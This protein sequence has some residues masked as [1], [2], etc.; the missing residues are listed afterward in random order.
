[1]LSGWSFSTRGKSFDS[2][3]SPRPSVLCR[4]RF[5]A[6]MPANAVFQIST[7]SD[8]F[9]SCFLAEQNVAVKHA[10][11]GNIGARGFEPPTSWSQTTRSTKLSYAPLNRRDLYH[12][13]SPAACR[14]FSERHCRGCALLRH[15]SITIKLASRET[16][17]ADLGSLRQC[18][19]SGRPGCNGSRTAITWT[20][21]DASPDRYRGTDRSGTRADR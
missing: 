11:T 1:M 6:I 3:K 12:T 9:S 7:R 18:R 21:G 8:I 13:P 5:A 2:E 20:P 14:K 19:V 10:A 4:L 17:A 16:L 15:L